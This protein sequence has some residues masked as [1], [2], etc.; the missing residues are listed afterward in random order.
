MREIS[1]RSKA[2]IDTLIRQHE[3]RQKQRV[4]VT[5]IASDFVR[6]N[7]HVQASRTSSHI[8]RM[9]NFFNIILLY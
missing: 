2:I 6:K 1:H 4:D 7:G 9:M 5:N 3:E 8:H